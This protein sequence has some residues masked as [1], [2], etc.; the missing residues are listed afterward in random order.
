MGFKI[1]RFGKNKGDEDYKVNLVDVTH[2]L[3]ISEVPTLLFDI[4]VEEINRIVGR[5]EYR[6]EQGRDLIYYGNIGYVIYVPY[7]G[8]NYAYKS[9]VA[10]LEIMKT[11][12]PDIEEVYITCNPDN[13]ASK[14]TIEKLNPT[15]LET[16]DIDKDHELYYFGDTQKEVYV[17]YL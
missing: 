8:H 1:Q 2:S 14:K 9:C 6:F 5:I 10:L 11:R 7:R 12:Y 15:Y 3:D 17:V 13:I 4:Y 16:V